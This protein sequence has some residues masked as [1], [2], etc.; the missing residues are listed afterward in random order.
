MAILDTLIKQFQEAQEKANAANEARY[1]EALAEYNKIIEL[2][3]PEGSFGKGFEAQLERGRTKALAQGT[4]QLVSSGLYG[5]TTAAGLGKKFEEEV[6]VPARL[7]MEDIRTQRLAE[8]R[9]AKAG[10]IERREDVGPDYATMAQLAM[11]AASS[12]PTSGGLPSHIRFIQTS[13]GIK[14]LDPQGYENYVQY[15]KQSGG[16]DP[17]RLGVTGL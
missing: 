9:Q 4:Q 15:V 5:T 8:A 2:Y 10:L 14:F 12:R 17:L 6:A 11:Q 13:Q 7:Q 16:H 1:N 3:S